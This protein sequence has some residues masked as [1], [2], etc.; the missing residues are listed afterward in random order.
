MNLWHSKKPVRLALDLIQLYSRCGITRSAAALAYFLL[1]TLFPLL[2]CVSFFI[3][4]FHLDLIH[5]LY[6]LEGFLPARVFPL[7]E[8]YLS[9]ASSVRS[10]PLFWASL[11]TILVSASAGLRVLFRTLD[12][13]FDHT[14]RHPLL[15]FLFSP[16]LSLVLLLVIYG[17]IVIL[18]TGNWFFLFLE[19]RLPATLVRQLSLT[20]LGH[21]WG[22]IR[23][24]L[25]FC[26]MLFLVLVVYWAGIPRG[27]VHTP[28]LLTAAAAA[29]LA[30]VTCS[31]LFSWFIDFSSRYTLVYGSLAGLIVLLAWLYFCGLTLLLVAA[32]CRLLH[33]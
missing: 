15:R 2:V 14:P 16:V 17:S 25:L 21:L 11:F 3:G 32:I 5:L 9:Y 28:A 4:V 20:G 31:A 29:A 24:L 1:L 30:L 19:A 7:F 22:W 10:R 18:F 13:L 8:D 27:A 23:Y 12:Q 26:A 6:E 33:R